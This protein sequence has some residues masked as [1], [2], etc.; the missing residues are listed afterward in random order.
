MSKKETMKK[1]LFMLFAFLFS[2]SLSAAII[3]PDYPLFFSDAPK[4]GQWA[5]NTEWCFITLRGKYMTVDKTQ[6]KV[7]LSTSKPADNEAGIWAVVLNDK[8]EARIYNKAMGTS[9]VLASVAPNPNDNKE[10]G[11]TF[12]YLIEETSLSEGV[13][14]AWDI[15]KGKN[16][17]FYLDRAGNETYKLNDRYNLLSFWTNGKASSDGGSQFRV[18]SIINR[19]PF[20]ISDAPNTNDNKWGEK[21]YWYQL[22]LRDKLLKYVAG[23]TELRY[24]DKSENTQKDECYWSFVKSANGGYKIYNK[25]AGPDMVLAANNPKPWAWSTGTDVH[26]VMKTETPTTSLPNGFNGAWNIDQITN[27]IFLMDREGGE[28]IK[29]HDYNDHVAF[30]TDYSNRFDNGSHFKVTPVETFPF[31]VSEAP[32]STGFSPNTTWYLLTINNHFL[33]YDTKLNHIVNV[34]EKPL[35]Y[36]CYWAFVQKPG[37][38][39]FEIYNA[40]A[41][42]DQVLSSV[43]V[44]DEGTTFPYM[45]S[46]NSNNNLTQA[47]ELVRKNVF[48]ANFHLKLQGST[49]SY[50]NKRG[51]KLA[52]WNSSNAVEDAGSTLNVWEAKLSDIQPL[53]NQAKAEYTFV[54]GTLE[55]AGGLSSESDYANIQQEL[56]KGGILGFVNA[57]KIIATAER[58]PEFNENE[59]Y[60]LRSVGTGRFMSMSGNN[61]SATVKG[62][63]LDMKDASLVWSMTNANDGLLHISSQGRKLKGVSKGYQVGVTA[64][65]QANAQRYA[66]TKSRHNRM[67]FD[68]EGNDNWDKLHEDPHQNIVGWEASAESSQWYLFPAKEIEVTITAAGYATINYPFAVQ[69]PQNTENTGLQAFVGNIGKN[70]QEHVF[71]LKEIRSGCIPA[72]TPVILTGIP[73]SYRLTILDKQAQVPPIDHNPLKG[74]LLTTNMATGV[75]TYIMAK[76]TAANG[77]ELPVGFYRLEDNTD[78]AKPNR[79]IPANKAYLPGSSIPTNVINK[80]GFVFSMEDNANGMEE[81]FEDVSNEE[82]YNLQGVRILNPSNGIFI[83]KS[84]K[85]VLFTK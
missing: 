40:G 36:G 24:C 6:Q 15:T 23:D 83:T 49:A 10:G 44:T 45:A 77:N 11:T 64:E 7:V 34:A 4:N 48:S 25:A 18:E 17:E 26:P 60:R 33:Y 70:N 68:A 47:W 54:N 52:F 13:I 51:D 20:L 32:T 39:E 63:D 37:S 2:S 75:T 9:M 59:Y 29:V 84:G 30:W 85:K 72:N 69:I 78:V 57:F 65:D 22:T 42:P 43:H 56:E 82:F 58:N 38:N 74:T 62:I 73:K 1:L 81:V 79:D 50:L 27:D 71:V 35:N 16:T 19:L 76:P 28:A 80:Q 5:E 14:G 67:V 66:L 31:N 21:T 61:N 46:K 53:M 41:G 3:L 8:K 55:A 12:P